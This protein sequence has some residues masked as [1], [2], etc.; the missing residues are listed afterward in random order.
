[1]ENSIQYSSCCVSSHKCQCFDLLSEEE[2]QYLY[3]DSVVIKYRK[4]ESIFKQGSMASQIMLMEEGLVKVF[5]ENAENILVLKIVPEGNFL[6][7]TSINE[8]HKT[9]QFSARAY[10]DSTIRQFDINKIR[11]LIKQ[12]A[13]FAREIVDILNANNIQISNR[14]FCITFKQAYGRLADI[15]L[16]ISDRVFKQPEFVLPLNRKELAELTGLSSETVIRLLRRFVDEGIVNM[17][18]KVFRILD[19]DRLKTISDKG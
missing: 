13:V 16:C 14:F 5:L 11:N 7:L 17:E 2:Y 9:Y 10:I 15:L 8:N 6:G 4:H 1:M 19:Y 3:S 18:G 12:N